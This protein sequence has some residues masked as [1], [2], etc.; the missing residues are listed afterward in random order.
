MLATTRVGLPAAAGLPA[1]LA[2]IAGLLLG[3]PLVLTACSQPEAPATPSQR[4]HFVEAAS[5]A[6]I[7]FVHERGAS[8]SFYY[9]E[10][11]GGGALFFD[12][13][14]DGDPDLYLA[15]GRRLDGPLDA[16]RGPRNRFYENDGQGRFTDATEASGLGD[17]RYSV[18]LCAGDYDNDGDVDVYVTNFDGGNA[19][20]HNDGTGRFHDVATTAGVTGLPVFDSACAFADVDGDGWLDLYVAN[21]VDHWFDNNKACHGVRLDDRSQM[22][23]YCFPGDYEPL[24][25]TLYRNRGD[26]TFED[27][28]AAWGVDV[29]GRSLGVAFGDYDNDGDTDLVV[30]CD[31]SRNLLFE[32]M[33]GLRFQE[34]GPATGLALSKNGR[35]KAGMGIAC[36]DVDGDGRLDVTVTYF[37]DEANGLYRNEGNHQFADVTRSSGVGRSSYEMLGWG[38]DFLDADLDGDVDLFVANGHIIDNIHLFRK[39][40]SPYLQR[41]L[42]YCN[43]GSGRF[44]S[45]GQQAGPAFEREDVSRGL[46]TADVDGDGDLD[47]LVTNLGRT[48][49]LYRNETPRGGRHWL[50]VRTVGTLSNRDGIGA[51]VTARLADGRELIREVRSGQSYLSQNE[52]RVH[53]GLGTTTELPEL[54]VRWPSGSIT[55]LRNIATDQVMEIV[56]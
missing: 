11:I 3:A 8:P 34:L 43:D 29:P 18:G 42:F 26:G 12:A 46:A 35:A 38:V 45:A 21:Y 36:G 41:N 33:D 9:V 20:Y 14:G 13:D 15:N 32:N 48:V 31:R 6:G 40:P 56:E 25:D 24:P 47:V 39:A 28:S 5:P 23:R 19:L 54:E 16:A 50:A 30:A 17:P 7:D 37:E 52:Q 49:E 2:C 53:F 27:V 1:T 4:V 55:T 10:Y 22:R 51:R 44:Q